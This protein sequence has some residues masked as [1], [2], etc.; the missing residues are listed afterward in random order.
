MRRHFR[1]VLLLTLLLVATIPVAADSILQGD[2]EGLELCPQYICGV[3]IFVGEFEGEVN[4]LPRHGV[5]VSGINHEPELPDQDGEEVDITGGSWIIR[6]PFRTIRGSVVTGV[7]RSH[8]DDTFDV[9][10]DLLIATP[11]GGVGATFEGTLRH[12]VFPP[13]IEGTIK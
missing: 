11:G 2:I 12:D 6:L 10:M 5:F 9:D 1:P 13:T 3:A 7:L 8:G 4:G